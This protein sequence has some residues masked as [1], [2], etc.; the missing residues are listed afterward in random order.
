MKN[1][2]LVCAAILLPLCALAQVANPVPAENKSRPPAA[3]VAPVAAPTKPDDVVELSPFTVTSDTETGYYTAKGLSSGRLGVDLKDSAANVS[4]FTKEL[5][6]DL[7]A[8]DLGSLLEFSNST[9]LDQ[10]DFTGSN[11]DAVLGEGTGRANISGR[12]RGLPTIRL[13]DY[14]VADWEID[15]YNVDRTDIFLG[16]DAILF[17]NGSSG[18]TINSSRDVA[19]LSRNRTVLSVNLGSYGR[20]RTTFDTNYV[21]IP[22]KLGVRVGLVDYH[23]DGRRM[24]DYADR[25]AASLAAAFRPH[26]NSTFRVSYD[27]GHNRRHQPLIN[28]LPENRSSQWLAS[29]SPNKFV[30]PGQSVFPGA[31]QTEINANLIAAGLEQAQVN[32][33][34]IFP[35]PAT[36]LLP[37]NNVNSNISIGTYF[38]G[39]PRTS[40]VSPYLVGVGGLSPNG[41]TNP[42]R[43]T[44]FRPRAAGTIVGTTAGTFTGP[45]GTVIG[46]EVLPTSIFDYD[47][48]SY[49]GPDSRYEQKYRDAR[50]SFEQRLAKDLYFRTYLR[51]SDSDQNSQFI[52]RNG[53][54]PGVYVDPYSS[55]PNDP[56]TGRFHS[57]VQWRRQT[58]KDERQAWVNNLAWSPNF[59][60][61]FGNHRL[62]LGFDQRRDESTILTY[63]E[64]VYT[65]S[66]DGTGVY[67]VVL[68]RVNYFD[69]KDNTTHHA[70]PVTPIA[71]FTLTDQFTGL[72]SE[73]RVGFLPQGTGD[74]PGSR[75]LVTHR[76]SK[77]FSLQSYWLKDRVITSYGMRDDSTKSVMRLPT[78]YPAGSPVPPYNTVAFS[79]LD[80]NGYAEPDPLN[81]RYSSNYRATAWSV[82]LHLDKA[83]NYSLFYNNS[84]NSQDPI[85]NRVLPDSLSP[86]A[87]ASTTSKEYGIRLSLL[88]DRISMRLSR[89]DT[90]QRDNYSGSFQVSGGFWYR[91]TRAGGA[92]WA[93]PAQAPLRIFID[94]PDGTV[95]AETFSAVANGS[96]TYAL[97]QWLNL[98]S[99][100]NLI[101]STEKAVYERVLGINPDFF[102]ANE[103]NTG[104][105][106][107]ED[108]GGSNGYEAQI[109]LRPTKNID[110][111]VNYSYVDVGSRD[112][113]GDASEWLDNFYDK[114]SR[115]PAAVLDAP[116]DLTT[117]RPTRPG[118]FNAQG[119]QTTIL[120]TPFDN[121]QGVS[122][123]RP[124][125]GYTNR[126]VF[127]GTYDTLRQSLD[128]LIQERSAGYGNRKHNFNATARYRFTE[129]LLKG[130]NVGGGY[131]WRSDAVI[132]TLR[133]P[134][135][136]EIVP[137][138]LR[139]DSLWNSRAFF[140]YRWVPKFLGKKRTLYLSG[141]IENLLQNN[142]ERVPL[143]LKTTITTDRLAG[144]TTRTLSRDINGNI[145]PTNFFYRLPRE[146]NFSVSYEF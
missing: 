14:E 127:A 142:L 6:A 79:T 10:A 36:G 53:I 2:K 56:Y 93:N 62:S 126:A 34:R 55:G 135:N 130:L 76:T 94:N 77:I 25:R 143:R 4:V 137:R 64:R 50:V 67:S 115:L 104:V 84:G 9:Q 141:Q 5:A 17:G 108:N 125:T 70:G 75:H 99:A 87:A 16:T 18:G 85:S 7:G 136:R 11:I 20:Q 19:N 132:A 82:V 101:N 146:Y 140:S 1:S 144:G 128:E 59:G 88:D 74:A 111:I 119:V 145:I 49:A 38:F 86:T 65:P 35:D 106:A 69:P 98:V 95:S 100:N 61:Y 114:V 63:N 129:G 44:Y 58:A 31:N 109:T 45:G 66:R 54:N 112:T 39:S 139:G 8:I 80:Y 47:N 48:I 131:T 105:T 121:T 103:K 22:N 42:S 78:Y 81:G 71:P 138:S 51:E 120:L 30:A 118:P 26:K 23:T 60:P 29:T 90:V 12:A 96:A 123:G 113:A 124:A 107:V 40:G 110:L 21:V 116:F 46:T 117:P 89:Y 3:A 24:W 102:N 32:G 57:Y 83:K 73:A 37:V 133:E 91:F 13:V 97:D 28:N 52:R 122:D 92:N 27:T 134:V 41:A 68:A 72:T 43:L 33:G 15:N